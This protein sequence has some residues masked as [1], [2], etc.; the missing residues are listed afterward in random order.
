M[1]TL[2]IFF[3]ANKAEDC[4]VQ[5]TSM[6]AVHSMYD[7]SPEDFGRAM[8]KHQT[9]VAR[10]TFLFSPEVLVTDEGYVADQGFCFRKEGQK[11]TIPGGTMVPSCIK[12]WFKGDPSNGY[13]HYYPTY[14]RW[15]MNT[16]FTVDGYHFYYELLENRGGVQFF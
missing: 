2:I 15:V 5:G 12:F 10:G 13:V 9:V 16:S 8:I 4:D 11:V 6:I 3:C 14:L 7:M 1:R